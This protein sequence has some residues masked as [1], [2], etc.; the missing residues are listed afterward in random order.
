MDWVKATKHVLRASMQYSQLLLKVH[1]HMHYHDQSPMS[2]VG[3]HLMTNITE[4]YDKVLAQP[5]TINEFLMEGQDVDWK[6]FDLEKFSS[7]LD[8]IKV[9]LSTT[10]MH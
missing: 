2:G 9:V 5:Q 3:T 8:S 4:C 1:R 10:I 7:R 6:D